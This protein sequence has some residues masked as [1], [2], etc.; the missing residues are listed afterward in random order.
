[1]AHKNGKMMSQEELKMLAELLIQH[2]EEIERLWDV[3]YEL[4]LD[5]IA[6]GRQ[7]S[8]AKAWKDGYVARKQGASIPK[9]QREK[10]RKSLGLV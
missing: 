10:L 8:D 4:K 2:D 7:L 5:V 6:S 1:M 9:M 3:I